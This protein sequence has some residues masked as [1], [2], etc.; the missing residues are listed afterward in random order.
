[1]LTRIRL[2]LLGKR[3]RFQS[4]PDGLV[5]VVAGMAFTPEE[6]HASSH[7]ALESLRSGKIPVWWGKTEIR[8]WETSVVELIR[9]GYDARFVYEEY[10]KWRYVSRLFRLK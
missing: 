10:M 5:A 9:E 4:R 1:M 6:V 2:S 3:I 7:P 8:F